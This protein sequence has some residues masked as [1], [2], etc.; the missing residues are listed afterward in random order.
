VLD[1]GCNIGLT[2]AHFERLWPRPKSSASIWT[3]GT[4][5]LPAGIADA[6]GFSMSPFP[7]PQVRRRIP[8]KKRGVFA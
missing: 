5:L 4:V 3:P 7:R 8:A 1:L 6:L 2:V